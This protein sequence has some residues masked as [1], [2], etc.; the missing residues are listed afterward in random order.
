MAVLLF[1]IGA[2]FAVRWRQRR[3]AAIGYLSLTY[4]VYVFGALFAGYGHIIYTSYW[5]L[6]LMDSLFPP[7][8]TYA[9]T[10]YFIPFGFVAILFSTFN[11]LATWLVYHVWGYT[12]LLIYQWSASLIAAAI[13]HLFI[14]LFT[15]SAFK[16]VKAKYV[17][18][19]GV[20]IGAVIFVLIANTNITIN[21]FLAFGVGLVTQGLLIYYSIKAMRLTDSKLYKRG[22]L[23]VSLTAVLFILFFGCYLI[24]SILGGWTIFLFI[25][26]TLVLISA[27]P[28]YVGYVLPDWFRRR[29]EKPKPKPKSK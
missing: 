16:E 7:A 9:L 3:S 22:F 15:L 8:L 6:I 19:Y 14:F 26:W 2:I 21:W 25:G 1:V 20:F 17:A 5:S 11:N 10:G 23:L 13:G 24:D 12:M 28:T 4:F 18:P 27:I 29:Y